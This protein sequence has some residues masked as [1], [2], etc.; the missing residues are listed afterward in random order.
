[1]TRKINV[2]S[3]FLMMMLICIFGITISAKA[4]G[5]QQMRMRVDNEHP[6]LISSVYGDPNETLWY[7]NSLTGVW[8]QIPDDVK[9]YSVIELHPGKVCKPKK[10][11]TT[12]KKHKENVILTFKN[13]P[14]SDDAGTD[15]IVSGFWLSDLCGNWG[16]AMDT[17]KWWEKN[18]TKVF[19]PA[20]GRDLRSYASEPEAM[21]GMEMMNIYANG[22]TVYNFECPAY[23][24]ASND[25]AT[26][27]FT[28]SILQFFRY[29]INNPAPNKQQVLDSTKVMFWGIDG[30]ISQMQGFY[31]DLSSDDET[32][33]LYDTGRYGI[34]PVIP[35]QITEA[36]ITEKFPN[37]NIL[38]KNSPQLAENSFWINARV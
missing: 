13:T 24:F 5:T 18:Y 26:P 12:C 28:K 8:N 36:E 38:T 3:A 10:F 17:W 14:I 7:G 2:I 21:L 9:P 11:Y 16:G 15:S 30:G 33:P 23:T 27:A 22:G 25:T 34:I 35:A 6:L 20:G 29:T 1:M 19:E 4:E 37:I 32:M 31:T